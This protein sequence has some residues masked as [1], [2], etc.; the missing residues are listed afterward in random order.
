[1]TVRSLKAQMVTH[2]IA[3]T[4][5]VPPSSQRHSAENRCGR[6]VVR[7]RDS[8][9][10]G[11]IGFLHAI[12][13]YSRLPVPLLTVVAQHHPQPWF[14]AVTT[15]L[16]VTT[17]LTSSSPRTALAKLDAALDAGRP[18]LIVTWRGLLPWYGDAPD[19]IGA[20]IRANPPANSSSS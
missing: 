13:D 11:G 19:Q 8:A 14:E 16:G 9:L 5:A 20:G 12:F 10:S 2:A 4:S 18:A 6:R 17:T 7:A 15:H 1:M 3:E